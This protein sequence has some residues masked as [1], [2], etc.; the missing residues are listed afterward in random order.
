MTRELVGDVD[1]PRID[2]EVVVSS[3]NSVRASRPRRSAS[4]KEY[5]E[6]RDSTDDESS[7]GSD[8]EAD[9]EN[10]ALEGEE[11]E[12][13][14]DSRTSSRALSRA[15]P[16]LPPLFVKRDRDMPDV[17][18]TWPPRDAALRKWLGGTS[19]RKLL[20]KPDSPF[21]VTGSNRDA[22]AAPFVWKTLK[23]ND[24]G[25][26]V[27]WWDEAIMAEIGLSKKLQQKCCK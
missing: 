23:I 14:M 9:Y 16:A 5:R 27:K 3:S 19:L 20:L 10:S 18:A 25:R 13:A 17:D 2:E 4:R 22:V 12:E 21:V 1:E 26:G 6:R 8:D 7:S 15:S 24:K 11:E